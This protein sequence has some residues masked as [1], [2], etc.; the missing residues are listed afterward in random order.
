MKCMGRLRALLSAVRC[1]GLL[2][3]FMGTMKH[4]AGHATA[5]R[6][7]VIFSSLAPLA[8]RAAE[9]PSA[10][11]AAPPV[12]LS[13]LGPD[14]GGA[15]PWGF[16]PLWFVL[17]SLLL[18]AILWT[19]LAWK[20]AIEEDPH[21]LRRAGNRE[22]RRLLARL[23]RAGGTPRPAD[24]HAWLRAA[25][26]TWGV[27]VSAPTE[28]EV[29]RSL[30]AL[31]GDAAIQAR[32]RD[33]WKNAERR[34]YAA[35]SNLSPGWVQE[36]TSVANEVRIPPR[37][38]WFPG[39]MRHWLPSVAACAFVLLASP[40]NGLLAAESDASS[41]P[42]AASSADQPASQSTE[43]DVR[44]ALAQD[45]KSA[46]A[47]KAAQGPATNALRAD[48]NNWT[49]HY[50]IAAQQMV[51][52]NMD[53]AV[54]HLTAAFL[55]H[56]VSGDVQ[57]NLRW[58][59]QQAG[60]MDPTL[61]RLLY[62]AWFQRYPA[63]L[64][65]AGWQRLGLFAGLLIG[66]GLCALVLPI[67]MSRREHELRL[68]GRWAVASG[69]ALLV[70][71]VMSWNAWGD[72]HRPNAAMLVEGINL[73]PAPTDLVKDRETLPMTAG[74]LT[75]SQASFLGWKQVELPGLPGG[76]VTGWIRSP[77]VM[78]LYATD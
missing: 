47:L 53:Y 51:Q 26:R 65:P 62:G 71:S 76:K 54:A 36:T 12:H 58:S 3:A 25:A 11:A 67:Y 1:T 31:E 34:L 2:R 21:R 41:T 16:S 77:Y 7:T 9:A 15:T 24:L 78:P 75:L 29:N 61:R 23:Q 48:W 13:P 38:H 20:R 14:S 39:R 18:P 42:G 64:S 70:V 37:K 60:S 6:F 69:I 63:L 33:L 10:A 4:M 5:P 72:L 28:G 50:D 46:A 27:R 56:P 35:D 49:A 59:L 74:S 8:A 57:D 55:Q 43:E 52:G 30:G 45:A 22:L 40:C 44:P 73:S 68:A 19:A 66:G 32:W 17:L